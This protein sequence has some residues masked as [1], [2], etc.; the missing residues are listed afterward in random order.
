[1]KIVLGTALLACLGCVSAHALDVLFDFENEADVAA[2]SLRNAAQDKLV[3]STSFATSGRHSMFFSTPAW[4]EGMEQWP[5]F[6]AKPPMA[7]W[8]AYDRLLI[9]ITN[10]GEKRPFLSMFISDSKIP[11][12]EAFS[13]RFELP[14]CGFKRYVVP[15]TDMPEKVDRSGIS[16]IHL[17]SQRPEDEV[18]LYLDNF[19]LLKPGEEPPPIPSS[20]A[21]ELAGLALAGLVEPT[22]A[23]GKAAMELAAI[24]DTPASKARLQAHMALLNSRISATRTAL[25]SEGLTVEDVDQLRSELEALLSSPDRL[26]SVLTFERDFDRTFPGGGPMLVGLATSME[27]I[28]PRDMPFS[29]NVTTK[30]SLSLARNEKESLQIAVMPRKDGLKEVSVSVT[31]LKSEDGAVFPAEAIDC[32]VVGY[33]ETKNRPPYTVP[34]V[35]WWPDPILDFLGPVDIAEGDLQTFWVR[36]KAGKDQTPGLYRGTLTVS[37]AN[38][39]PVTLDLELRVRNF[40]LPDQTPLPTAITFGERPAQMGGVENWPHMKLVWAD[41]LADYYIDYDSL[42][43]SGPPDWDVIQY[44]HNQGRLCAFNLGNVFNAG[45][46]EEGFDKAIADTVARLRPAYEKAK[47]LGLLDHAYIYG[48]D[49]RPKEQFGLLERSAQ[50]L[51]KAFPEVLLMTTSYDHSYGLESEVKTIDAW[52]PLTPRFIPE[53]AEDARAAGKYVWWY[54]CCGPHN[55]YANW[56]VEY[57]AIESRLLMGAMT[58]KYRPDGFLYYLISIWNDNKPIESGP[59]T[60]WNP[61]SWT[62]YHGDGSLTCAGPGGKPVPTVRLENYRDGMEDYAYACI[63]EEIIRQYKAREGILSPGERDWLKQAEEALV[64][65]DSLVENMAKYS[66]DPA[67]LYE[68]R[69]RMADLIDR[70]GVPDA[71]P[72]GEDFGVRGFRGR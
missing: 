36:A 12:R 67:A 40:T 69:E 9:D 17:F 56:F 48:F 1:M 31:D 60:A 13:Y 5:A 41:F 28:L 44:L 51:R 22:S 72:W 3:Q 43:R 53:L 64:V 19:T 18:G 46:T 35:G 37:A 16:I 65:P 45:T 54:I 14:S 49:E 6:E 7:D 62:T 23:L 4:K 30:A 68:Y 34:Y 39:E 66:H 27:K 50:A 63:L 71:D 55:P 26:R 47:E 21:R 70:S 15:L 32:D 24:A 59:F 20:F 52:C 25:A 42:Y 10:T 61:V 33:V 58:A 8:R 38:A 2:W 57:A 11:F 29:L